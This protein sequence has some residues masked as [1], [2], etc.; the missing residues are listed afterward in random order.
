MARRH[1]QLPR[2]TSGAPPAR[3][4]RRRPRSS[5]SCGGRVVSTGGGQIDAM[6]SRFGEASSRSRRSGG[7]S[8][9]QICSAW[10]WRGD[11]CTLFYLGEIRTV[12]G[13][14]RTNMLKGRRITCQVVM[15]MVLVQNMRS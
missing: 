10:V 1:R 8:L 11:C 5:S 4:E 3:R 6:E 9:H 2:V 14:E 7:A 13:G 12:L 15:E